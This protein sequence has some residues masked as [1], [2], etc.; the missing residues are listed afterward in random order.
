MGTPGARQDDYVDA[1]VQALTYLRGNVGACS[2]S[3][4]WSC[5]GED[6]PHL[7]SE[8]RDVPTNNVVT[9]QDYESGEV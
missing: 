7:T 4:A 6:E 2:F 5:A 9:I 3:P 1:L 8:D